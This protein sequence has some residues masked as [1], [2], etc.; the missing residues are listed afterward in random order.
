[1]PAVLTGPHSI[2]LRCCACVT[3]NMLQLLGMIF[4]ICCRRTGET[5]ALAERMAGGMQD[6][7]DTVEEA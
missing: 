7:T 4:S 6:M 2:G 1:M 3:D 5:G